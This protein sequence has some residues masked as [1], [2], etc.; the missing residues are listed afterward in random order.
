MAAFNF[1]VTRGEQRISNLIKLYSQLRGRETTQCVTV[2][3]TQFRSRALGD[4]EFG[5]RFKDDASSYS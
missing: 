5:R 3:L 1:V 4:V 2:I